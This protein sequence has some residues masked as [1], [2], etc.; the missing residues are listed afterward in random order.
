MILAAGRGA[1]LAPLTDAVP[2]PLLP[3][4]EKPLIERIVHQLVAGGAG[5]IIINLHYRGEQIADQLGDGRRFD[6]HIL[7]SREAELLETGGGIKQALSLLGE[8]PFMLC[9]GDIFT[10]FD[11]SQ[12]PKQLADNDLAHLL[13]TPRPANRVQGDFESQDGRLSA[14]GNT[15]VYCGIAIIH[16]RLF[17]NSP[18]GA[19][20]LADLLFRG[21]EEQIISTQIYRGEWRDIGTIEEYRTVHQ[22][23]TRHGA[24]GVK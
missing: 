16:P 23:V 11:F 22:M 4:A 20:S 12:L 14:R 21:V 3:I 10:D 15:Y 9:N 2:K 17:R 7:Y 24:S 19:F 1:R 6:T 18:T 8:E 5:Q 13:L